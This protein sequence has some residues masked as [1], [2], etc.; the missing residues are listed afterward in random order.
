MSLVDYDVDCDNWALEDKQ[1][2]DGLSTEI[3]ISMIYCI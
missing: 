1:I 3:L 2:W